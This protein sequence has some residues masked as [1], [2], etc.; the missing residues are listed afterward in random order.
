M[1]VWEKVKSTDGVCVCQLH[2]THTH[3]YDWDRSAR[4]SWISAGLVHAKTQS[5]RICLCFEIYE[6]L[7]SGVS[8]I[9]M[10]VNSCFIVF[11]KKA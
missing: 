4:P 9:D 10:I 5:H 3:C 11:W 1:C 2:H 7:E 8:I 6:H